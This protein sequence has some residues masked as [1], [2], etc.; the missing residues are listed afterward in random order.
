MKE[1]LMVFIAD[2]RSNSLINS[3][4]EATTKQAIILRLLSALR[5]N[6][7]DT[8]EV[9]PEY[10]VSSKRVD[11]SLRINNTNKVFLEV[12]KVSEDLENHQEQLLNYSF[13][14]GV[15]L[16]ILTNGI[17]WWFYLPLNEGNWEQRRFY[18]IDIIQQDPSDISSKF[19]DFLGKENVESEIAVKKAE[20]IYKGQVKDI[21]IKRNLPRAWNKLISEPDDLLVDLINET[22]EKICG[23]RAEEK[24]IERF[25]HSN[26]GTIDSMHKI[27]ASKKQIPKNNQTHPKSK[28]HKPKGFPPEGTLCR[29]TYK[30]N[31][32]NGQIKNGQFMVNGHGYF[33][34]FSAAS[35]EIS[36]TSRN[37]WRDWELKVPG[38][39]QWLL[40]DIWRKR[41][42]Q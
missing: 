32:Y 39:N 3:F 36:N 12:K 7:F 14:E 41:K 25:L 37:G 23:Y 4:D 27:T 34:S 16:A 38:S 5:W 30:G 31:D 1:E 11:Y 10:S 8:S 6:I 29:F 17:T 28:M 19:I 21:E 18:A 24:I 42:S 15:K 35:V 2:L 20:Q 26:V 13:Q 9:Q 33:S 22:L 40:A